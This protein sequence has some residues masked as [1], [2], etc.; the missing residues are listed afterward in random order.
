MFKISLATAEAVDKLAAFMAAS[1]IR[2]VKWDTDTASWPT[3]P[4]TAEDFVRVTYYQST[5]DPAATAPPT[6][7]LN[8]DDLWF[9][10]KDAL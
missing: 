2:F 4:A 3:L 8:V 5:D 7:T 6:S 10:H 9:R 1:G